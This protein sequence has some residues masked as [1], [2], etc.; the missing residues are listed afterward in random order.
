M[1]TENFLKGVKQFNQREFY[2]CHDTLEAIW[3]KAIDIDKHFYQGILQISVG[4]YHLVNNNWHGAVTLLGEG[5]RKLYDYQPSY[6]SVDVSCLLEESE[7]LLM[8]LH[9][10]DPDNISEFSAILTANVNHSPCKLPY[11]TIIS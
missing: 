5:I 4:C 10:I 8:Y 3:V 7:K 6:K 11:I 1:T 9:N 2:A